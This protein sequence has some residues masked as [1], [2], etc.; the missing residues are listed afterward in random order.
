[1]QKLT[2]PFVLASTLFATQYVQA[3]SISR[4]QAE[5]LMAEC[6]LFRKQNI[7]PLKVVEIDK[8]IE[9]GK[10]SEKCDRFY[11]DFGETNLAGN[12]SLQLGLFWDSPICHKALTIE[13]YFKLYPGE[14]LFEEGE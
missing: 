5:T 7:E 12:G 4:S 6:K 10:T 9:Q 13:K 11:E 1:M 2:L 14:A 8:C 3:D